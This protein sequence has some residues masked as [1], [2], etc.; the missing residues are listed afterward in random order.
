VVVNFDGSN[1]VIV[2]DDVWL[3]T[4]ERKTGRGKYLYLTSNADVFGE[5]KPDV[6]YIHQV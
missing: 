5:D 3:T 6:K 4:G 1:G 2:V